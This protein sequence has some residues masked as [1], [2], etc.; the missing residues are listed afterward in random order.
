MQTLTESLAIPAVPVPEPSKEPP[1][2][3]MLVEGVVDPR[4]FHADDGDDNDKDG[5]TRDGTVASSTTMSWQAAMTVS[6]MPG[7]SSRRAAPGFW[8]LIN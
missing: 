1:L 7:C 2:P 8:S 6:V 5:E 3:D 4:L